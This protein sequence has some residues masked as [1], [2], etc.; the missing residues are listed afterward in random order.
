MRAIRS[1]SI[2]LL[3]PPNIAN[4]SPTCLAAV[5]RGASK[6]N[7]LLCWRRAG[8][9]RAGA[10]ENEGAYCLLP[11]PSGPGHEG[12]EE[13]KGKE[14]GVGGLGGVGRADGY[15]AAEAARLHDY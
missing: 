8:Q 6:R 2:C 10:P 1:F 9:G 14:E 3:K 11:P 13:E 5:R 7:E 4:F 12:V 15:K